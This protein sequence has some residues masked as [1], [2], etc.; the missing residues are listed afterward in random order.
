[1]RRIPVY[2]PEWTDHNPTD[3][4]ITLLE[5]VAFLGENLQYRFN[6]IPESAFQAFLRLLQIRLRPAVPARALLGVTTADLS[7][8]LVEIATEARAGNIQFETLTEVR[9][10][11]VDLVAVA[12][13]KTN[14]TIDPVAEPEVHAFAQRALDALSASGQFPESA[15]AGLL[16]E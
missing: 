3:P 14:Q 8:P 6:Q 16:R 11:P 5:L 12:R 15:R 10:W 7:G 2:M 1:M 9:V 4:G 13:S